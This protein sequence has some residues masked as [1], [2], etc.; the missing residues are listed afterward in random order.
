MTV[1]WRSGSPPELGKTF[2]FSFTAGGVFLGCASTLVTT[3]RRLSVTK[4]RTTCETTALGSR[5]KRARTCAKR[6]AGLATLPGEGSGALQS[7]HVLS[8]TWV[9]PLRVDISTVPVAR[10]TSR[11]KCARSPASRTLLVQTAFG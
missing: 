1:A 7:L 5:E 8:G 11:P 9:L 10:H 2:S 6:A 3:A 4:G